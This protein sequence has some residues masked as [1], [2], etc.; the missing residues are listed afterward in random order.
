MTRNSKLRAVS[1]AIALILFQSTGGAASIAHGTVTTHPLFAALRGGYAA[2]VRTLTAEGSD[3]NVINADGET[4]LMYAAMYSDANTVARLLERGANPNAKSLTGTTALML[5]SGS[6]SKTRLLVEHGADVNARSV[7]G[8]TPL[9]MAASRSGSGKVV[10]YLLAHGANIN[11][12]DELKGMAAI[13]AG[14]GGSTPLIE[15]AKIRDGQALRALL[16]AGANVQAK[17]NS[18]AD[19][20]AAAALNGNLENVRLLLARGAHVDARV[21]LGQITPLTFAAWRQDPELARLLIA[22]GAD[23]NVQDASGSTPLMWSALNEYTE[24]ATTEVL[25]AWGADINTRN[26][27]GETALDWARRRGDTAVVRLLLAKGATGADAATAT[28]TPPPADASVA[29]PGARE[30]V[31]KSIALLQKSSPEFFKV[32]GCISC[33]NQS[34]PQMTLAIARTK[35]IHIDEAAAAKQLKTVV[36]VIRPAR[37]PLLEMSDVV[38]DMAG[39]AGYLMLG[40]A[41]DNYPPDAATDAVALNL[42]AK[43]FPD[44]SWRPW[45]P[46]PPLEFS[47]VTSTALSV[48][49]LQLYG[50]PA[51]RAEFDQ[52]IEAARRW[53]R[54]VKPR[55]NEEKAMR[56]L[57]LSWSKAPQSAV[58]GA[59]RELA[60]DQRA[61]GGW[62][63]LPTLASDAYAT[64]QAI[65]AL[66]LAGGLE[67]ADRVYTR[68]AQYLRL[69]QQQDGSWHVVS[70][71]FP[72]QP[73]KES[74][75]PHGKDQWL[76]AAGTSWAAMALMLNDEMAQ[77][78]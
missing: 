17:D 3:V 25:L 40:M 4:P 41:A 8:R 22:S 61:D 31:E 14:S 75:F 1:M 77:N 42:A 9:L 73:Y 21:G 38:P 11:A 56:L 36:G 5:A 16:A 23:V 58:D 53:L 59:A 2:T 63:Q 43:Q 13:P 50:P 62:A 48:R 26:R 7:T 27:A 71:T 72:F 64:G 33:H 34:L 65:Y 68:A 39:S 18:G 45:A 67:A 32:S 49:V 6:I 55:T 54:D 12:K 24:I 44:G 47:A 15:A 78:R 57:G 37:L 46:R 66:R 20:L 74:G 51:R 28:A 29:A 69:T 10:E 52:R 70:R 60:A 76:S 35:L 19:A 30:A